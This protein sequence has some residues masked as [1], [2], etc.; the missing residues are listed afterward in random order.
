MA[1]VVTSLTYVDG[2]ITAASGLAETGN[3]A[4]FLR[5][6]LTWAAPTAS[7]AD[8]DYGDITVSGGGATFTIDNSAVTFAKMQA[9]GADVLLGN[10]GSGS[11]VQEITCTAAGRAILDDADA[12]AQRTTLGVGTA[13]SPQFTAVNVGHASDTTITRASAGVLAVEGNTIYAAGGTDVA[14]ADGGTGA[15]LTDPNA[16]RILFWD[17]SAGQVTWLAPG[18]GLSISGTTIAASGTLL[19][20]TE[21]T[22]GSGTHNVNASTATMFVD[23]VGGGGGGGGCTNNTSAGGGAAG[24]R[25]LKKY[26]SPSSSYSYAVGS[27][28]NGGAAGAN[29]GSAGGDTT[30]GALTAS[31]G[32]G[33]ALG[34]TL[35]SGGAAGGNGGAASGGDLNS[36]GQP[37]FMGGSTAGTLG[38]G[39]AGGSSPYGA[40]GKQASGGSTAGNA[41]TGYGGGG[42]GASDFT[43]TANRA[44]GAGTGGLIRVWEYS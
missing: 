22:S 35:G 8:G 19:A 17:D 40:G 23:C 15:S 4:H 39:G 9:V 26:T 30:F 42:G 24:G 20:Y 38:W 31:G 27:A 37:G 7:L 11:T 32:A 16:D 41:A 13:D 33:G 43:N 36:P 5:A 34:A 28:G 21:Y 18:A 2:I 1:G 44:G 14:L 12:S 29:A 10:D 25:V 6:D 3:T